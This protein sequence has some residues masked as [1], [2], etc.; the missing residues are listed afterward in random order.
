[1]FFEGNGVRK[2]LKNVN[3]HLAENYKGELDTETAQKTFVEFLKANPTFAANLLLGVQLYPYQH[4]LIKA[5]EKKDFGIFVLSRG[6]GKSFTSAIAIALYAVFNQGLKIAILAPSWRQSKFIFKQIEAFSEDPKGALFRQCFKRDVSKGADAWVMTIGKTEIYS[7]PLG[8]GGKIRGYRF[9]MIFIDEGLLMTENIVNEVIRPFLNVQSDPQKR[10][11]FKEAIETME[12]IGEP[13][14]EEVVQDLAFPNQKLMVLSSASYTFE[15]LY[16]MLSDYQDSIY[17]EKSTPDSCSKVVF[18][19]SY[20]MAPKGLLD[21]KQIEEAKLRM[22]AAQFGREYE[23]H[24]SDD[25]ASFFSPKKLDLATYK[26]E[27]DKDQCVFPKL[28]GSRDKK[29]VLAI[30]PNYDDAETSDHFAMC[31]AELDEETR[32]GTVVHQYALSKSNLTERSYY[33]LYLLTNFNIV[34]IIVD[35]AGGA[36]FIK[37]MNETQALKDAGISI[38]FF[39]DDFENSDRIVGIK[40]SLKS[41]NIDKKKICHA[42][43]FKSSWIARANED[44]QMR[45]E[46]KM[47]R[48]ASESYTSE[49]FDKLKSDNIPIKTLVFDTEKLG[50]VESS[51][52]KQI[53]LIERQSFLINLVK[54]ECAMIEISLTANGSQSFDLPKNLRGRSSVDR[55]R[56]DSYSALLLCNYGIKCYF[57]MQDPNLQKSGGG[58]MPFSFY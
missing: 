55:A 43:N 25:A 32:S 13:I 41:Y 7:I 8:D 11:K 58:F 34:Y 52:S 28:V 20:K 19:M 56:K 42:Q 21:L 5:I 22:S 39:E 29:Y 14:P 44:L 30:D 38:D 15:Y 33:Y 1:M 49:A 16:K 10:Q 35:R 4:I 46:N 27:I 47:I 45:L 37:D 18:Q 6:F 9:N 12:Q 36:K 40:K 24:F 51:G 50:D 23:S 53:D 2:R 57:D 31:V 54:K 17:D 48:F 3:Q 26:P